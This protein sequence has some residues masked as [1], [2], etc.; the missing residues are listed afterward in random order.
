VI[1]AGFFTLLPPAV[2][3]I[4]YISPIFWTFSGIIKTAYKY[5]DTYE[6]V[7][8]N[9]AVGYNQCFLEQN[10]GID[11]YKTRGINVAAFGDDTSESIHIQIIMLIVLFSSMQLIMY[12]YHHLRIKRSLEGNTS[13][14]FDVEYERALEDLGRKSMFLSI[15]PVRQQLNRYGSDLSST[16]YEHGGRFRDSTLSAVDSN[17]LETLPAGQPNSHDEPLTTALRNGRNHR[18]TMMP[19]FKE[20]DDLEVPASV[21]AKDDTVSNDSSS[22]DIAEKKGEL[23]FREFGVPKSDPSELKKKGVSFL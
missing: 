22:D 10:G 23:S 8:G 20:D 15:A 16:N 14:Q 2:G 17:G 19:R 5:Y 13:S 11:N 4:R 12:V 7:K 3:W 21:D 6:C 9:S 18:G 1:C